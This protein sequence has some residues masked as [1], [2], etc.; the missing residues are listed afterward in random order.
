MEKET[1]LKDIYKYY[2]INSEENNDTE[3]R[4]RQMKIK[5]KSDI[6][7]KKI[8]QDIANIAKGYKVVNWTDY[9]SCCYEFKVL[10]AKNQLILD[11]D[12]ELMKELNGVRK[13]LRIFISVLEPY[14]FMFV[15]ETKYIEKKD[16]WTFNTM[17]T[18]SIEI[19]NLLEKISSYLSEKGYVELSDDDVKM[20]VPGI[21]TDLKEFNKAQV[22]DCL[23]TDLVSII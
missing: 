19:E 18:Y 17:K 6:Q 10:L 14:Y 2:P 1:I 15:E 16:K 9:E 12:K 20:I 22:F 3:K 23:F 8:S 7:G 21:Q 11:D 13:D 5:N 4:L